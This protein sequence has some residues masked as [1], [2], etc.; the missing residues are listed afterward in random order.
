MYENARRSILKSFST[1]LA[2][3]NPS[4]DRTANPSLEFATKFSPP[5]QPS[6]APSCQ[7]TNGILPC[8]QHHCPVGSRLVNH[9]VN[10]LQNYQ[11]N[12]VCSQAATLVYDP[13]TYLRHSLVSSRPCCHRDSHH[14][15]SFCK[16]DAPAILKQSYLRSEQCVYAGSLFYRN[17]PVYLLF[18]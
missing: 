2:T 17:Y 3:A 12:L 15:T 6:S 4:I 14:C 9:L 8:N 16:S 10:R 11:G 13:L 1:V 18:M 5:K 7:P